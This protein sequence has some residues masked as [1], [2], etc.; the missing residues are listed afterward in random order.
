M[1][2]IL[3]KNLMVF[4]DG[5]AMA[6]ATNHTLS[7]E[8]EQID[9]SSKDSGDWSSSMAGKLTWSISA[10]ALMT[11][12]DKG[13]L[14]ASNANSQTYMTLMD[15]LIARTPV[16]LIF[17]TVSNKPLSAADK[18]GNVV[19]AGGWKPSA[20]D[21]TD[22]YEGFAVITS[23]EANASD[24]DLSSYSVQFQGNGALSKRTK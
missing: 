2:N 12:D 1:A 6:C 11:V 4:M 14:E 23:I 20:T 24:G 15:A 3:G 8:A 22:G 21:N 7:L 5:K 10:E 9:V 13:K 19:P 17:S 18:D 16:K